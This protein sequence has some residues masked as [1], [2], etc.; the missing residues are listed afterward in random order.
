VSS[1][2]LTDTSFAVLGLLEAAGD[3][4]TPYDLK[5]VAKL[6]IFNFWSVPHTQIYMECERM[7][8]AGL[9]SERRETGGRRR[10]FYKLTAS[11]RKELD[12]WRD[13]PTEE[14][15]ELRD[16][17]ALKLFFGSEPGPLAVAQLR[18]HKRKLVELEEMVKSGEIPDGMRLAAEWGVSAERTA[19][20]F[21]TRLLPESD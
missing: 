21:W 14:L 19:I 18:A 6:S 5:Q 2:R 17:G 1:A 12:R 11:G 3:E 13:E 16:I 4:A 9:L 15:Y 10:R 7:A 20:R 8:E